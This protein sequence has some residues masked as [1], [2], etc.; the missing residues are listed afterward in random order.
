[1][2]DPP[3]G[4]D[5]FGTALPMRAF[6]HAAAV[7]TKAEAVLVRLRTRD[8]R[9]GW[10]EALPRDYVT[11]ETFDSV[12]SDIE[13]IFWPALHEAQ[14]TG[15][16]L[17][18][19]PCSDGDRVITAARCA[20]EMAAIQAYDL[21]WWEPGHLSDHPVHVRVTGVLG[22]SKPRKTAR[23]LRLMRL[24]GLRDFKLKLGFD[25]ATDQAN[26]RVVHKQLRRKLA[27]AA[28]SLR[29]DVNGAWK[30]KDVVDRVAQLKALGVC[31]VE[32]PCRI[33][34]SRLADLSYDC[35]L[36][37]IADESC[38]TESD[39][40]IL[41]GAEGRVWPNIR[42]AKNGGLGPSLR[43]ARRAAA[44]RIPYV[45]GCL[46][47]ESGLLS[48]AQ[49]A[50]LVAAPTPAMVEGNFGPFLLKDDLVIPSPRFGWGGRLV[51]D[52]GRLTRCPRSDKFARYTHLIGKLDI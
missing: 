5:M 31:A 15:D 4:L 14:S 52:S 16:I 44:E 19:L 37:L 27:D 2:H 28:C 46:V 6:S 34:P 1:M 38:L 51:A 36:P 13:R 30:Y 22:S 10:G 18:A 8:G 11:G 47:G 21:P 39:A 33:R 26:L 9:V 7:R 32:Q 45:L 35:A 43:I 3:V 12:A 25:E 40:E 49:R 29:V 42:L 17:A 23:Q 50:F 24:H 41:F 20:V 48:L